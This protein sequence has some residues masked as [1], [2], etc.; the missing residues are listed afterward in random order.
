MAFI[1]IILLIVGF[2]FGIGYHFGIKAERNSLERERIGLKQN[3]EKKQ[4]ELQQKFKII[5]DVTTCKFLF[6]YV[7]NL[8]SDL[9]T[10]VFTETEYYLRNKYR[11]ATRAAEEIA[12]MKKKYKE[13]VALERETSYKLNFLLKTYPELSTF[14]ED[15]DSITELV[16]HKSVSSLQNDYDKI[17]DYI[18]KD[19][20]QKLDECQRSQLALDRYIAGFNKTKWQIGRDYELFCGYRYR[21]D[22]WNVTQNGIERG[23]NDLGIDIIATKN[24]FT[25]IIQCKY[26]SQHKEIHENII[27]QLY[28]TSR[29]YELNNNIKIGTIIPVFITNIELSKTA[30]DFANHLGVKVCTWQ[31]ECF[32]RIKCN[33]NGTHKIFHLPFDQQYDKTMIS[34]DGEF[35]AYTVK[36]AFDAGFR[37]AKKHYPSK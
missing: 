22:G 15:E 4:K 37:R 1:I 31:L 5:E 13:S 9:K 25:H 7:A 20:Y 29:M 17:R 12:I 28:G 10:V 23:I 19:E 16:I 21:E 6:S 11:P 33:I 14:I 8:Y 18:S 3:F 36:E 32:P 34:K 27:C 2:I 26:W 35:Y 30:K 24:G